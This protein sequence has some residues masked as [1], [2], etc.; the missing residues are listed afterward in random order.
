L[1]RILKK[2]ALKRLENG[3]I[4]GVAT[5]AVVKGGVI[6]K[7]FVGIQSK[8]EIIKMLEE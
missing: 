8:T 3:N 5:L 6:M 4:K 2:R 1:T 7:K